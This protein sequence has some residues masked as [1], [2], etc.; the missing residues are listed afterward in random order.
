MARRDR[1]EFAAVTLPATK[2]HSKLSVAWA[3][4]AAAALAAAI[5]SIARA[6]FEG[7]EDKQPPAAE[8]RRGWTRIAPPP[9]R[10]EHAPPK[11]RGYVWIPGYWDWRDDR[12]FWVDGRWERARRGHE[13]VNP[14]WI[15]GPEGWYLEPG[16][17]TR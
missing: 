5:P 9:V 8:V 1:P 15:Q 2:M 3:L 10:E 7:F 16:G 13:Y 6:S 4:V 11:R 14:R 12:F 17:W